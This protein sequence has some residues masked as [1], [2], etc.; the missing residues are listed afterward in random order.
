MEQHVERNASSA[1]HLRDVWLSIGGT[2]VRIEVMAMVAIFLTFYAVTFGSC[3]RW[4]SR[5]IIQKVFL[6]ANALSV[7]LGTYSIG[8]M[9]SSLVK[10]KMYPVW[11]VSLLA[12]FAS[13]DSINTFGL[14]YSG[15]FLKL[16]YQLFLYF[17]YVLVISISGNT[18][19]GM[20]AAAIGMLC[21][22]TLCKGFHRLMAY[23]LPTRLRSMNKEIAD[24]MEVVKGGPNFNAA[25][26]Q[27]YQY[28][29]DKTYYPSITLEELWKPD[30]GMDKLGTDA[31]AYKDICLSFSLCH[32]LQRRFFG[33]SC[34]ES[35]RPETRSFVLEGL[36]Q[37][38]ASS[39]SSSQGTGNYERAFKVIEVELAFMYDYIY[40]SNAFV[41]Y[42]EA[43]ACTAWAIAS[44][45]TTCFLCVAV[46]LQQKEAIIASSAVTMLDS[47]VISTTM[48]PDIVITLVILV[49][50]ASLQV[51]QLVNSLSSNWARVSLVCHLFRR[52]AN[53]LE[54]S[55]GLKLRLFLS[56]IKLLDKYQWQ[57]KLGQ[58]ESSSWLKKA[59][60]VSFHALLR[61]VHD[62]MA[63][64]LLPMLC[65]V[66]SALYKLFGLQYIQ[67]V[68]TDMLGISTA[69]SIQLP[70]EVKSAVIDALVGI[71]MPRPNHDSVVLSSGSTS[72]AKNGLQDK[73]IRQYAS[74]SYHGGSASTIIPE[75]K[76]N[77]ASIILT[78]HAATGCY[79][80]DY[81]QRK[82]MKATTESPLQHRQYRVVATALSKYCMYLVAYVPQLL[83]GQQSYTT[84]V[85][86]DFVRSPSYILQSGTQLKDEL[87]EAVVEDELRW[88][89]LA[90]FWVEMLLYLAPSDNVTAHIEQ[91]AQG[92]E[93]I[94][95]LWA[96]LFHAGILYRP[97]KEEEEPAAAG[98]V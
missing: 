67:Q 44:I 35:D 88:K 85:Y 97:Y 79:D 21:S 37:P 71:L 38:V 28:L 70:I 8:L 26:M 75:S 41:H 72:L 47:E 46:A 49:S 83:P 65:G 9:Q 86:N 66:L 3:R 13:I 23:V 50:L 90:D 93:F 52:N 6:A 32:L 61:A 74:T 24:R 76:G 84:S 12:L 57:N 31:D 2:V 18:N 42:Y 15:Q 27:G 10:S 40:S 82:K 20:V 36:L 43:G 48:T 33:F 59:L 39:S 34:A 80:K 60:G 98:T 30:N 11:S 45:L 87:C 25:I 95:H 73:F 5:W 89:V 51:L 94:T 4:S 81:E 55:M 68:L 78:W 92:G 53:N 69:S 22:V 29:V 1:H 17:G 96:L 14:D 64:H 58:Y 77:Q 56:R 54:P 63:N 16:L 19:N 91:L 62:A 7:S